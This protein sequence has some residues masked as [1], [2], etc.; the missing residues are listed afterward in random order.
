MQ[1]KQIKRI[2]Q[3]PIIEVGTDS[4]TVFESDESGESQFLNYYI[5]DSGEAA[6]RIYQWDADAGYFVITEK[7]KFNKEGEPLDSDESSDTEDNT[8]A[9]ES[10]NTDDSNSLYGSID[11]NYS[12]KVVRNPETND[13][14]VGDVADEMITEYLSTSNGELLK[15]TTDSFVKAYFSNDEEGLKLYLS[16]DFGKSFS[17]GDQLANGADEYDKLTHLVAKWYSASEQGADVQYEFL[18]DGSG[19]DTLTYLGISLEYSDGEFRVL[20]FYFEK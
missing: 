14:I 6:H 12:A 8:D 2:C 13:I 19:D 11:V 1:D 9:E 5:N 10:N 7:T 3:E 17:Y 16:E 20:D 18:V 4:S 15:Q